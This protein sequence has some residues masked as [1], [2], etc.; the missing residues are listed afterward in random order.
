MV[1][2]WVASEPG[3][4]SA[5]IVPPAQAS[6]PT[7]LVAIAGGEIRRAQRGAIGIR[8]SRWP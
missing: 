8:Q 4:Q 1:A 2:S 3:P 6:A 7:L 5:E